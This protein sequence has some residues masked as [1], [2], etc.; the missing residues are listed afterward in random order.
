MPAK[1]E[2]VSCPFDRK[3]SVL[4]NLRGGAGE[5]RAAGIFN[6]IACGGW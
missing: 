3:P 4:F 6:W 1:I 2:T 5:R